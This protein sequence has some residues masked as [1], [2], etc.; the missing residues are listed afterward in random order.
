LRGGAAAGRSD[1]LPRIWANAA[2]VGACFAGPAARV[3]S[4]FVAG[5]GRA[6]VVATRRA[7]VVDQKLL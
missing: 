4:G 1:R 3:D 5:R 2:P 7:G 6:G